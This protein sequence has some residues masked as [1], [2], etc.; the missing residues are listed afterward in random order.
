MQSFPMMFPVQ[1]VLP[2]EFLERKYLETC[3]FAVDLTK[4]IALVNSELNL[5]SKNEFPSLFRGSEKL[6]EEYKIK[7]NEG[8]EQF[9]LSATLQRVVIPQH[10]AVQWSLVQQLNQ[11][12]LCGSD[13]TEQMLN[14]RH[15]HLPY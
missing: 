8:L 6:D 15:G 4:R 11:N 12:N 9:S 3:F 5:P 13:V 14:V 2:M 7:M 10:N 1:M